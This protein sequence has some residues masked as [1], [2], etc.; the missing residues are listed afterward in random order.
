MTLSEAFFN[1]GTK[2]NYVGPCQRGPP[3]FQQHSEVSLRIAKN[4]GGSTT[5]STGYFYPNGS[6]PDNSPLMAS[7]EPP[8]IPIRK[9]SNYAHYSFDTSPH[10]K[11]WNCPGW[12]FSWGNY[13]GEKFPEGVDRNPWSTIFLVAYSILLV[14]FRFSIDKTLDRLLSTDL[15]WER[16]SHH[17]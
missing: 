1:M 14:N 15:H 13:L 16:L 9:N 17:Y 5:Q 6:R 8:L 4:R 12:D 2:A 3:L 7:L 11:I 10:Q